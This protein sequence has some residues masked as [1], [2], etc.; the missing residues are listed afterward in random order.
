[1][2]IDVGAYQ[3]YRGRRNKIFYEYSD[4]ARREKENL[5]KEYTMH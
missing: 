5:A 1:M 3:G 2:P 4:D